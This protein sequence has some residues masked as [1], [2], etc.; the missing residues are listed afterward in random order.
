MRN[1]A[2]RR[3]S[4]ASIT[5]ISRLTRTGFWFARLTPRV[6]PV[7][8][9]A[10][11]SFVILPPVWRRWWFHLL[12]ASIAL[13]HRYWLH[14]Y[15]VKRLLEV[16]RVRTRIATDLHDDIGSSLSQIA[17]LSEVASRQ[18]DPAHPKLAEP[19]AD[20]AG[21]SRELVDSMS[22]IVWA[23]DP[24]QD[25][26]D[27]LVHRM[28]RFASDVLSPEEHPASFQGS[29]RGAGSAD[30]SRSE[31]ADLSHLQRSGAQRAAAFRRYG[32]LRRVPG[33][34][35]VAIEVVVNDNGRGFDVAG[36]HEGHGLRSMSAR[37]R[38]LGG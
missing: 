25:H 4:A 26:L 30:G 27:D 20:I 9:P 19:L 29:G 37:A 10:I 6:L 15:R 31:A 13:R 28:R 1:G 2:L 5:R 34:T 14:H 24:E 7:T 38:G 8:Q 35:R 16:E 21:I 18:V 36:D 23:I 33:G 11:V 17:I 22:D 32:S 12:A 3:H